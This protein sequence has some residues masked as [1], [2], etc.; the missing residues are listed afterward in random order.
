MGFCSEEQYEEFLARRRSSSS[1][2]SDDG[3]HLFKFWFS[4][5]R[6]TAHPLLDPQDRP[7]R[8]W[9]LSPTD[10]ASLKLWDDATRPR[11][12]CS[13]HRHP[14]RTLDGGEEQRQAAE[15]A[16]TPCVTFF[17]L[18][19]TRERTAMSSVPRTRSSWGRP[20]RCSGRGRRQGL[21]RSV[22]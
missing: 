18:S 5:S 10:I 12:A 9:K 7:V 17:T 3:I 4:V 19:I 2:L 14:G 22:S 21:E 8:R 16:S 1:M 15:G 13:L 11:N 6:R 20:G